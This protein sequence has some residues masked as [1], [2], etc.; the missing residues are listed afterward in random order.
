MAMAEVGAPCSIAVVMPVI[1]VISVGTRTPGSTK[2]RNSW[3]TRPSTTSRA[4]TSIT[5]API[6]GLSPVV[7]KSSTTKRPLGMLFKVGPLRAYFVESKTRISSSD[8][9]AAPKF[10]GYSSRWSAECGAVVPNRIVIGSHARIRSAGCCK[11][12]AILAAPWAKIQ[13]RRATLYPAEL[14]A[15]RGRWIVGRSA[16][17]DFATKQGSLRR[18]SH[19]R[20]VSARRGCGLR[21]GYCRLRL[22]HMLVCVLRP[23]EQLDAGRDIC[24]AGIRAAFPAQALVFG[25]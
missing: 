20:N 11:C 9:G 22:I 8:G 18:R 25:F 14:G 13:L 2:V 7:S 16:T 10:I 5:R 24:S 23:G 4:D 17:R 12:R 19:V 21:F 3:P 1:W 6:A 15:I